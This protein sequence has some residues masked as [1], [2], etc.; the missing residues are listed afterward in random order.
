V[1]DL[2]I[3]D[4]AGPLAVDRREPTSIGDEVDAAGAPV[5]A[6]IVTRSVTDSPAAGLLGVTSTVTPGALP[7]V[8]QPLQ[9]STFAPPRN[10]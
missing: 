6:S 5:A 8:W 3:V 9:P 10:A 7:P 2:V 1:H 4:A